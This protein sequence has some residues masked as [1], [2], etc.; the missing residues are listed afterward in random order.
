MSY[1]QAFMAGLIITLITTACAP[2]TYLVIWELISP[3]YFENIIKFSVESG[4]YSLEDAQSYFSYRNFALQTIFW[5]LIP[6]IIIS[7]LAA[8]FVRTKNK[9]I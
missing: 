9:T 5:A 3:H 2:L 6:G 8:L 1:K 4:L 7:L